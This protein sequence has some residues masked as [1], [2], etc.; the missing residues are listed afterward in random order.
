[1]VVTGGAGFIGSH[2]VGA[3]VN[4][5]YDVVVVDHLRTGTLANVHAAA[6][7]YE[8]DICDAEALERVFAREEPALVFHQAALANVQ[9]SLAGYPL[10]EMHGPLPRSTRDGSRG[11][12]RVVRTGPLWQGL[13]RDRGQPAREPG[14]AVHVL[15]SLS[16]LS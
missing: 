5:G 13:W 2:I 14:R 9:A 8:V 11:A 7:F 12:K 15:S 4:A 10:S 16:A 1:V 6:R 3:F